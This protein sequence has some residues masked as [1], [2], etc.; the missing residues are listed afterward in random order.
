MNTLRMRLQIGLNGTDGFNYMAMEYG[1]PA[2]EH[3]PMSSRFTIANMAIEAGAKNGVF[4]FDAVAAE[5]MKGR[6]SRPYTPVTSQPSAKYSKVTH[7]D[8][9]AIEPLV[10]FPHSPGNVQPVRTAERVKVDQVVVGSC[11]NGHLDDL[12]EAAA[13]LKGRTVHSDVRVIIVPA[14]QQIYL[15]AM[16]EGLLEIFITAGAVVSTPTCGPCCGG[17]MGVLGPKERCV[18]TTNRN[19]VGRMG[20]KTSEVYLTNASVAAATAVTGHLALP[21]EV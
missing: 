19:F 16:R 6:A 11:T 3:L 1:G 9:G 5:Y 15:D 8:V 13:V 20:H 17:H 4:P 10:A 14:T 7:I 21:E 12:R 2:L 18:S